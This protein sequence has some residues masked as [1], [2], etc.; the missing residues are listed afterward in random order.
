MARPRKPTAVHMLTGAIE[1]DPKRFSDR[2][3]EP[4]D[5]RELGLPQTELAREIG[6]HRSTVLRALCVPHPPMTCGDRQHFSADTINPPAGIGN[7]ANGHG[8]HYPMQR[9]ACTS[10]Q[11][12][13]EATP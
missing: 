7:C 12:E 2:M 13:Q 1:H 6:C 4:Q 9:H 8:M 11:P 5:D 3:N 10:F